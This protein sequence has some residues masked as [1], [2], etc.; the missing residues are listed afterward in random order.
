MGLSAGLVGVAIVDKRNALPTSN[1]HAQL[2]QN[3]A[4]PEKANYH[5]LLTSGGEQLHLSQPIHQ[6]TS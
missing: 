5:F 6:F 1:V 4:Q 2:Q 3:K